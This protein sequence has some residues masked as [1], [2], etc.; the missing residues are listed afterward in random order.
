MPETRV[1]VVL[2]AVFVALCLWGIAAL[3]KRIRRVLRGAAARLGQG[4]RDRS[5]FR[6]EGRD[7][8]QFRQEGRDRSR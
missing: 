5:H 8:S 1:D 4:D 6:Q 2:A 7:R 3:R